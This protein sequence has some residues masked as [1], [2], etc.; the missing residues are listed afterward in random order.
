MQS[1]KRN[2]V[3]FIER[4]VST[5][6]A[7]GYS[8]STWATVGT[9]RAEV[10]RQSIDEAATGFGEAGTDRVTFRTK[11]FTGLTTADRIRFLGRAFNVK[12]ILDL[13]VRDGL[14]ITGEASE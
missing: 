10:A 8:E 11:Y 14:E 5:I 7:A 3:I 2:R 6:N 13:G 1:G 12:S 4:E 9:V